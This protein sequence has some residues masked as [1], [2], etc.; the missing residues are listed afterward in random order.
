MSENV[1]TMVFIDLVSSTAVKLKLPG[2]DITENNRLYRDTILFPHRHRVESSLSVYGG[3]KVETI[4]DAFFLVFAHPVEAVEWAIYI[5]MSHINDPISTP[6]GRLQ[7]TVGMHTGSPLPDGPNFIGHEVDYAARVAALASPGQILL[8]EAT[9]V[10][11]RFSRNTNLTTYRHSDRYLKGIGSVPIFEV[12]YNNKQPQ[13]LK[14]ASP[15]TEMANIPETSID[16]IPVISD[17]ASQNIPK[18][19]PKLTIS[20]NVKKQLE[21]IL[22][23][24]IGPMAAFAIE[25]ALEKVITSEELLKELVM[26]VPKELRMQFQEEAKHILELAQELPASR[27]TETT[28]PPIADSSFVQFCQIELAK[29]IGPMAVLIIQQ[30]ISSNPKLTQDE[31][32]DALAQKIPYSQKSQEFRQI[33]KVMMRDRNSHNPNHKKIHNV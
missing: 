5:H 26:S 30:T 4:G 32:I 24:K 9:E 3:R 19:S 31:L 29:L 11:V 8:S 18:I 27:Q 16:R 28:L 21:S 15:A 12:L 2:K 6:L 25:Q 17:A 22:S 10:L 13:P 1:I 33:V 7:I 14:D 23:Q 20:T